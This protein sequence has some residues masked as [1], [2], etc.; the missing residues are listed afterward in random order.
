MPA[1]LAANVGIHRQR[2]ALIHLEFLA[3]AFAG[4]CVCGQLSCV[5]KSKSIDFIDEFQ[6]HATWIERPLNLD[7]GHSWRR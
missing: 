5:Q 7:G 6:W 1:R 2:S 4:V 3:K